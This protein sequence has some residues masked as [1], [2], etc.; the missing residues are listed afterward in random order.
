MDR[1]GWER[2]LAD[3]APTLVVTLGV[4]LGVVSVAAFLDDVSRVGVGPATV[5]SLG[6]L[7]VLAAGLVALSRWLAA[8]SLP[9]EDVWTVVRWCLGGMAGFATLSALTVG[10]R[11]AQGR[12]VAGAALV[13]TAMAGGGGIAGGI[14]GVYYARAT[15]T[16]RE[17][18]RRRDALVFLNSYLRHNV[19]NATQVIQGYTNLLAQRS[20]ADET[21]LEP[22]ERRSDAIASL[23]E[24]VKQLCDVFSGRHSPAPMDVSTVV[25]REVEDVQSTHEAATFEVD[26]P[27][28]LYVMATDAVSA[29]FSNLLQNAVEH[30]DSAAPTVTVSVE[31]TPRT[32]SVHVVD[33]GPGIRDEVK[34]NLFE[35]SVE[36]GEGRGIALVKTLMDHYGGELD[37]YDAEPRGTDV[38][39]RFRR[40]RSGRG[41]REV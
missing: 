30:N 4:V 5:G 40:P 2:R 35:S 13:V 24:D 6:L 21:Y 36:S 23:I 29:V 8:S 9:L 18:G 41:R 14:A 32:V 27:S 39:V 33:D 7:L 16:A 37:V 22:I 31:S 26:V 38:V 10:L 25:L 3:H 28:E 12:P 1:L 15:R 20:D 34:T 19:L 11:L 17:S